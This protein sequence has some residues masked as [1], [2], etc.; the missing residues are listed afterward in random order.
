MYRNCRQL[1]NTMHCSYI[2]LVCLQACDAA[3]RNSETCTQD[4]FDVGDRVEEPWGPAEPRMGALH[5]PPA[6]AAHLAVPA[7]SAQPKIIRGRFSGSLEDQSYLCA[8]DQLD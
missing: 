4:P 8:T 5:D 6:R 1:C 2:Y 7:P 3:Q